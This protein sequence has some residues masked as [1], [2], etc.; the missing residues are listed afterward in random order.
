[1]AEGVIFQSDIF[2]RF[3]LPFVLVS[4]LIY[5]IL[6]KT[7]LLGEDKHQVN[8]IVSFVVGLIFTGVLYPV[9]VVQNLVLFLVVA[10]VILFVILLLWGFIFGGKEGFELSKWMK[11]VLGGIAG[12]AVIFGVFWA[13]GIH[14]TVFERI[15]EIL[16]RQSWSNAFWTNFLFIVIIAVVLALILRGSKGGKS[17]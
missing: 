4:V 13:T 1:M 15:A 2:S 9:L 16:F 10:V 5:A 3:I 14:N 8:A 17:E 7:K 6:E 11:Y 12:I